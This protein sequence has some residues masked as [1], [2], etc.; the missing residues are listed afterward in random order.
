MGRLRTVT[1]ENGLQLV[2]GRQVTF[3]GVNRHDH[4]PYKGKAVDWATML[5][6][7]QLMKRHSLNAV[8]CSHYPNET[9]WLEIC[10]ALGLYVIDEAN[11]ETHGFLYLGDEGYISKQ[12]A[13]R[14]A[15]VSRVARM[16]QR[17][18]NHACI[19]AWSLGNECGYGENL[20]AM[21]AW[22]RLH[23]PSRPVQ[24]EVVRNTCTDIICPMYQRRYGADAQHEGR[25]IDVGVGS[26]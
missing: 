16:V 1:I 20:E 11:L 3:N 25:T 9:A 10:D 13:W 15:Y 21:A 6:D 2:N 26:R 17:D 7:A 12:R 23:E 24:Y 5:H 4:C 22:V 8:R 14:R 18:K 19:I